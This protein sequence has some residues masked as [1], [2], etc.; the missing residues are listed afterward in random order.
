MR[1]RERR[2]ISPCL[3]YNTQLREAG[4]DVVLPL[5][6]LYE[7]QD[8]KTCAQLD[9]PVVLSGHDHHRVDRMVE[10]TRLLKPGMDA[11]Y[12]VI[13]DLTWDSAQADSTPT[14]EAVTIPVAEYEAD[15]ELEQEMKRAYSSKLS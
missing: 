15:L 8:E 7:F 2:Y 1:E 4:C 10:G 11:H 5:C 12:A 13:L 14:V 9:V 3:R 6:H